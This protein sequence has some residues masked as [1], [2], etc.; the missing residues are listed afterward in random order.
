ML[1]TCLAFLVLAAAS[2]GP[3][4][5][6]T[7]EEIVRWIYLSR[8]QTAAPGAQ[9]LEYLTAPARRT[10]FFTRRMVAFLGADDSHG[11]NLATACLDFAPDIPGNDFDA[12]EIARTLALGRTG[13]GARQSITARF[14]NFGQPAQ[15]TYDFVAEDG[16]MRIDDIAGPGYRLSR[17]PC[18][19]RQAAAPATGPA[20][21]EFCYDTG[22]GNLRLRPAADG[23]AAFAL[24]SVQGGGHSCSAQGRARSVAG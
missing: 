18:T 20:A 3:G 4:L 6:Q 5:A 14:T 24:E 7:P 10:Q 8:A 22:T 1:R 17:I 16:F 12:G 9:G 13:D 11:G 19:A 21:G 23:S 15:V 2:A